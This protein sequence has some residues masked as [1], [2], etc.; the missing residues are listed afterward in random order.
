M[1]ESD[2]RKAVFFLHQEGMSIRQIARNLSLS[3]NSVREIIKEGGNPII[4]H[5]ADAKRVDPTLIAELYKDCQGYVQRIHEKLIE[6]NDIKIGYST[7]VRLVRS[8]GL[9]ADTKKNRRDAKVPDEPGEEMQHDTSP[10]VIDVGGGKMRVIG[11]SL[12]LRYSKM[13]YLKFYPSFNRFRMKCFFHE[14]LTHFGYTAGKCIIDNTNL[15]VLKGTGQ[16][17]VMVPEMV[18]FAKKY[19]KGFAWEAHF[20]R[21]S[22]R[23]GGV[24]SGFWFVETNFFPGRKFESIEDL[25]RQAFE[26]ATQRIPLRPHDKTKLIPVQLFEFEKAYLK[27]LPPLVLPPNLEHERETDQYGYAA[28]DG[29]YYWVPGNGRGKV[30]VLQFPDKI[31]ILRG[32]EEL[33]EYSLPAFGVKNERLRP[34]GT[35]EIRNTPN[36]CKRPTEVEEKRLSGIAPEIA[37]YLEFLAEA[38]QSSCRKYQQIRR[39]FRLSQK[40]APSILI[41]AVSR[42]HR[43]RVTD[44]D[45]LERIAWALLKDH[46]VE[47]DSLEL[48]LDEELQNRDIYR[49]GAL[50]DLPDLEKYDELWNHDK[51][52]EEGDDNGQGS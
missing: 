12:Y 17:A 29:N 1:I 26:W 23:K 36:N 21:H 37:Q 42:A 5:R 11:S 32:R 43:Y 22:D 27:K 33:A 15:A 20:I 38:P 52:T 30:R 47:F 2:K 8:M 18:S 35:P 10:Y 16:N 14:A 25:N 44:S 45:T 4:I 34:P 13:R 19:Y 24:E 46:S 9:G 48:E 31:R 51:D 40:L 6:E 3:R 50:T 41:Q 49:E 39:L 28:F 7:L